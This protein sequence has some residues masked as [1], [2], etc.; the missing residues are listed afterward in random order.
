MTPRRR[1]ALF[2]G[3]LSAAVALVVFGI[4]HDEMGEVMFNACMLCL[5]CIGMG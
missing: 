2:A 3:T 5:S 1:I 4:F